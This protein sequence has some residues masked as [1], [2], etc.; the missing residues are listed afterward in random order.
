MKG[1]MN[2]DTF[3]LSLGNLPPG[4]LA[5][6]EI[7]YVKELESSND[8]DYLTFSLPPFKYLPKNGNIVF[9]RIALTM[10]SPIAELISNSHSITPT[11]NGKAAEIKI[12]NYDATIATD[13]YLK[14][15]L[16]DPLN[17]RLILEKDTKAPETGRYAASFALT[18]K[19]TAISGE[20]YEFVFIVDCSGSMGGTPIESAKRAMKIFLQSL[21]EG[22]TF[23]ILRFGSSFQALYPE[24]KLLDKTRL[25][26]ARTYI[27]ATSANLGGTE[28]SPPLSHVLK[29]PL[30][31]ATN[32]RV[33]FILTDGQ[34]TNPGSVTE[35]VRTQCGSKTQVHTLG[36]GTGVD[37]NLVK[38]IAENGNG[39]CVLV[40]DNAGI[41]AT[42][43]DQLKGAIR[44][45]IR[46]VQITLAGSSSEVV[47]SFATAPV[48]FVGSTYIAY[49]LLPESALNKV[50]KVNWKI[51]KK[52]DS[53][54]FM[55]Q[56]SAAITGSLIHQIAA[57]ARIQSIDSLRD[58]SKIGEMVALSTTY[59]VLSPATSFIVVEKNTGEAT[60]E[61]M[62]MVEQNEVEA[63]I[64]AHPIEL[65]LE[66]EKIL[67]EKPKHT[68]P[69]F[70]TGLGERMAEMKKNLTYLSSPFQFTEVATTPQ[71]R[72]GFAGDDAPRAIFP[73]V[74]GRPRHTGVMVGMGQ[75]DSY[76]GDEANS[77]RGIL[78]MKDVFAKQAPYRGEMP[79]GSG[80]GGLGASKAKPKAAAKKEKRSVANLRSVSSLGNKQQ[81]MDDLLFSQGMDG[82]WET[83]EKLAGLMGLTLDEITKSAPET[84]SLNAWFT[85]VVLAFIQLYFANEEAEW[86][87]IGDKACQYLDGEGKLKYLEAAENWLISLK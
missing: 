20:G 15:K 83:N 81:T 45:A 34:V 1:D 21:P 74:I 16:T 8:G 58:A 54:S 49:V 25:D 62:V 41:A 33:V 71:L 75:K 7:T 46:D 67:E 14:I 51:G 56:E 61:T 82:S 63:D 6:T 57:H 12:N 47:P 2:A 79:E 50:L 37:V 9:D 66:A 17:L 59:S 53:A 4:K 40:K 32:Q 35:L 19:G 39:T 68:V 78:T 48:I 76:I 18:P 23:N 86:E 87:L 55:L 28:L 70:A 11:I 80:G 31:S 38:G 24:S 72:F 43:V 77:K 52:E 73:A 27:T 30:H 44:P 10:E 60:D 36:L 5:T 69:D 42:I 84:N 13:F 3:V 29:A 64:A 85:A 65:E 26:A 22:C